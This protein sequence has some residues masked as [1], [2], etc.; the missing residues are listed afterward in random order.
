MKLLLT[1]SGI[2]NPS[3]RDALVELLGKP[4]EE[5]TALIV[6]TAIYP[7]PG[8]GANAW[9]AVT[10]AAKSPL[11]EVGWKSVGL[12][13]AATALPSI[14]RASWVPTLQA[15]DALLV[16]GGNVLYLCPLDA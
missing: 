4:I 12:L 10:G 15:T 14:Q 7:F 9:R 8:G 3:I 1:S 6:P 13:V 11:A 2:A 16:W 5:S